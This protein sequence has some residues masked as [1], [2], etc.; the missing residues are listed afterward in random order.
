MGSLSDYAELELLDHT[1]NNSAY[2]S[3]ATVYV[4]LST[5]D[6]LDTAAGLAEPVGNNYAR[7]AITFGAAA[8]RRITQSVQVDFNVPSGAWGAI[9][10]WAIFDADVGG[11]M[12]AHGSLAAPKS[13][14]NGSHPSFS[15]GAVYVEF[16][17]GEISTYLANKLLD[18]MFRNQAYACPSTYVGFSTVVLTDDSTG[19]TVTEP[20]GGGYA[21]V[22]VNANGG[23]APTWDLAA[24]GV[25]D[26]THAIDF[27]T[28]SGD[29]GTV[30]ATF[31]V[32]N[33][34]A[35]NILF[36]D[37]G[38]ADTA[39]YNGDTVDFPIGDFDV[40]MS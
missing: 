20:A 24:A 5:A 32:D 38:L 10:H 12:L 8:A 36:Y 3:V 13:P 34:A 11:N 19:G 28:T 26:N 15:V 2:A 4:G 39:I 33:A 17:A 27:G 6:P 29:W 31:V 1:L 25:V 21:R 30:V 14:V 18:R 37:N 7:E 22:Q 16:S 35:G 9:T 40:S 23:G